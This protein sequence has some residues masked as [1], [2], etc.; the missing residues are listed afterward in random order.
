ME[1]N[2]PE[3]AHP[4]ELRPSGGGAFLED[5]EG[6]PGHLLRDLRLVLGGVWLQ[7]ELRQVA[8]SWIA[9][10]GFVDFLMEA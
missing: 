2:S 1:R 6:G 3:S 7:R 4:R 10:R 9:A 5:M 8:T